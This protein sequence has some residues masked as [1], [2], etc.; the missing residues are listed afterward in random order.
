MATT[1]GVF[2]GNKNNIETLEVFIHMKPGLLSALQRRDF[3]TVALLYNGSNYE[4]MAAEGNQYDDK[5][6]RASERYLAA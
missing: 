5:L 1:V 3:H 2:L 6:R 4:N